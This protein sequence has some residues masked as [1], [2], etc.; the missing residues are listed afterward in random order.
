MIEIVV[1]YD[2]NRTSQ[3]QRRHWR[4]WM[5]VTARAKQIARAAWV[6]A[7][8]PIAHGP[9]ILDIIVRRA[10]RMDYF[11]IHGACKPLIDGIFN[12]GVTRHDGPTCLKPGRVIQEQHKDYKGREQVVFRCFE[13]GDHTT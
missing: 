4:E 13:E 9:V 3:N 1:H 7:G 8:K 2:I 10:R 6:Q 5:G 12:D 11:N